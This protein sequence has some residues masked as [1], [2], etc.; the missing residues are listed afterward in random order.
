MVAQDI[1]VIGGTGVERWPGATLLSE[2]RPKTRYGAPSA[3]M[4]RIEIA[5]TPVWFL[6]RHGVGH[7]IAPHAINYRANIQALHDAGVRRLLALNAVGI[8]G[9]A[10]PP[11][12]LTLPDQIIDYTSGRAGTFHDGVDAPLEHID[13]TEPY[14]ASLREALLAAARRA[15]IAIAPGGTYGATQGPRLETRAEVDRLARD[16]VQ[17][18]G[19]T[20]MPEAA[21]AR[22]LGI[23]YACIALV[24]NHAAGRGSAA[25]DIHAQ[26]QHHMAAARSQALRLLL[27][28]LESVN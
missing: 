3:P 10:M 18:I 24:V 15:G 16:G 1:G 4:Q 25:G 7:D 9:E 2:R 23:D 13:F 21:L 6:S 5:G 26:L 11:G 28:F 27:A 17:V 19:M 20:G 12:G 14:S 8:I 22:E